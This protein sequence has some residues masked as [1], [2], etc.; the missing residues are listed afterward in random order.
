[1][2]RIPFLMILIGFVATGQQKD[3]DAG[4][5]DRLRLANNINDIETVLDSLGEDLSCYSHLF[6]K[7]PSINPLNPRNIKRI[8]SSFGKRLHPID[9]KYKAHNGIDIASNIGTTV[10]AAADGVVEKISYSKSGYGKSIEIK[11]SYGFETKYAHMAIITVL[12]VGQKVKRGEIVGM[13]GSTGKSTGNHLHYEI[14]KNN[15]FVDPSYFIKPQNSFI[16]LT[17]S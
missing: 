11:H 15:S 9:K 5:A 8:S 1:M 2:F 16:T 17:S 3:P 10:H 14:R 4:I 13:V 6:L 12:K 7:I